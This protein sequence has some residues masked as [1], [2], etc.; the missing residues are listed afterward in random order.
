MVDLSPNYIH[1]EAG[2]DVIGKE[3]QAGVDCG[4]AYPITG[5]LLP[6]HEP[7]GCHDLAL[8]LM[9]DAGLD[10][11]LSVAGIVDVGELSQRALVRRILLAAMGAIIRPE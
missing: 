7:R 3:G 4:E 8:E 10:E 5:P 6:L 11:F 9:V 1:D 2:I